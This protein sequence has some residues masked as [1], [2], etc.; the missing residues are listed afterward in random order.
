M[1]MNEHTQ[2]H[3][4]EK[5]SFL[6]SEARLVIAAGALL[7]GGIPPLTYLP[8]PSGLMGTV[9]TLSW[10]ISGAASIY[11]LYRWNTGGRLL[12]GG[13][14][15]K[16]TVAFFVMAITGINLGL[17]PFMGNIGMSISS[18]YIIFVLAAVVYLAAA[19]Y[20]HRRW[21]AFGS[22]IF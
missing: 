13:K 20:L 17:V 2:P 19:V 4:L 15:T 11:L 8:L 21:K 16:D 5:Y 9:L 7:L 3:N 10:L 1:D 6:W 14:D 12:F 18:N 22:K